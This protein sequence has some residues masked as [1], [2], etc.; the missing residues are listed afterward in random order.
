MDIAGDPV[1]DPNLQESLAN[2]ESVTVN[3]VEKITSGFNSAIAPMSS[4]ISSLGCWKKM[5]RLIYVV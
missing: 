4:S 2:A 5:I 3:R 1:W